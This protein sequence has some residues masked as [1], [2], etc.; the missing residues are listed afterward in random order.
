GVRK[1]LEVVLPIK[2]PIPIFDQEIHES[3]GEV[4]F[5]VLIRAWPTLLVG[6]ARPLERLLDRGGGREPCRTR[7]GEGRGVGGDRRRWRGVG[8]WPGLDR[9]RGCSFRGGGLG[10]AVAG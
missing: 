9:C 1:L 8:V 10:A 4:V 7:L 2:A 5:D 3:I 6:A